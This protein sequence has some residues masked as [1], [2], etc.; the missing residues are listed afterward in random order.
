MDDSQGVALRPLDSASLSDPGGCR[1]AKRTNSPPI[2]LQ[3]LNPLFPVSLPL[4]NDQSR[5]RQYNPRGKIDS[6]MNEQET[7]L[8][9][10]TSPAE[11]GQSGVENDVTAEQVES[12]LNVLDDEVSK[13]NEEKAQIHDQLLRTMADFQN[14]RKRT[15]QEQGLIRQYA[16]ESLIMTL[17]PV[18]DN[19]ERTVAAAEKGAPIESLISGVRATEKQFRF[20]IE[21]QGISRIKSV[22]Q[23]YDSDLHEAIG[24]VPGTEHPSETIIEEVEPGYKM[25]DKVIRHSKVRVA[26]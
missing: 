6:T 2:K 5:R 25:G 11:E 12:D 20:I 3:K 9:D 24:T 23:P 17:L 13:L 18:M 8:T 19:F 15:Q 22:G 7:P 14:F 1:R 16:T 10:Q 26:E 21:Q 4:S